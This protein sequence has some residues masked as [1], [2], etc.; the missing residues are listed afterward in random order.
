MA[1]TEETVRGDE[2]IRVPK[3]TLYDLVWLIQQTAEP[4]NPQDG[5]VVYADGTSW[6]PSSGEGIYAYYNNTW[7][8]L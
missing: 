2:Y 5:W 8:K 6:N 3:T 4:E 1:T 7:N